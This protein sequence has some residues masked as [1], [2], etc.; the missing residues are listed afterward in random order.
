MRYWIIILIVVSGC[1]K[2][3]RNDCFTSL[4]DNGQEV[5]ITESYTK[6]YVEDRMEVVLIQD[7]TR[8][9]EIVINGPENL[10]AQVK[11]K[12]FDNQLSITNTNTCNFV[13]SFDYNITLELYIKDIDEIRLE[14]IATVSNRDTLHLDRLNIYHSALSDISLRINCSEEV[15]VQS[16]NS[17]HTQLT[18][19]S[20]VLKG[21]IEEI[22]DLDASNLNCEEVLLDTHTPLDC[23]VKASKG[24]FVRIYN[25]GNIYYY[26]EPIDY[27]EI[28]VQR[29]TG[30]L[31]LVK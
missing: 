21:S 5:R 2:E 9:G 26:S 28:N 24:I 1:S 25:T 16:I 17:A 13:R 15:Y 27:K 12:V 23:Y 14:S 6:I 8:D 19:Y 11:T 31:I 29:G 18:G 20:R 4:G 7:S 22:S 30:D 10:L 3:Q